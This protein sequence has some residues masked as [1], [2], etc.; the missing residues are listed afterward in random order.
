MPVLSPAYHGTF[1]GLFELLHVSTQSLRGHTEPPTSAD[2]QGSPRLRGFESTVAEVAAP[3]PALASPK[4]AS[5]F[6][7]RARVAVM[8]S[9][10]DGV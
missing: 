8:R 4:Q 3:L 5:V 2:K 1:F 6:D 7:H 9:E 10:E